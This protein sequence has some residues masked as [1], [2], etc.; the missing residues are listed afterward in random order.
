MAP[1]SRSSCWTRATSCPSWLRDLLNALDHPGQRFANHLMSVG[2]HVI[3]E[4]IEVIRFEDCRRIQRH[5]ELNE[6][7]M[8][9]APAFFCNSRDKRSRMR[10]FLSDLQH[11]Q[12]HL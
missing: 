5:Q 10:K 9:V 1:G 2:V 7:W 8:A 6:R 3:V 12:L 4:H 11:N